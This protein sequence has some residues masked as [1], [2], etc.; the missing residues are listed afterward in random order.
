MRNTVLHSVCTHR[1][2][3]RLDNLRTLI[4][5]D[6]EIARIQLATDDDGDLSASEDDDSDRVISSSWNLINYSLNILQNMILSKS[7]LMFPNL[8]ML[9]ISNNCLKEIPVNIYELSNLS[10]LNISGNLGK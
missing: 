6:N 7:R 3:L 1:R 4:L 5:T 9:D 2:H 8:S 10:V